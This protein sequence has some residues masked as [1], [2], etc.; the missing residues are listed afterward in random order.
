MAE[1][2]QFIRRL[3][4]KI[5]LC[6]GIIPSFS[7]FLICLPNKNNNSNDTKNETELLKLE[8]I[9]DHEGDFVHHVTKAKE[10][11]TR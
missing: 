11:N 5:L 2:T 1:L 3:K 9:Q 4:K 8:A 10:E 6:N 7:S